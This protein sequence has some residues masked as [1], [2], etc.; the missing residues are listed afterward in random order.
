LGRHRG[1]EG[2]R[3]AVERGVCVK[4]R[5]FSS[6]AFIDL[7]VDVTSILYVGC[8]F[9]P[10]SILVLADVLVCDDPGRNAPHGAHTFILDTRTWPFSAEQNMNRTFTFGNT[11]ESHDNGTNVL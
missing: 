8:H 1:I 3:L 9:I 10:Y 5:A 2:F 11:I 7:T 4:E 6:V